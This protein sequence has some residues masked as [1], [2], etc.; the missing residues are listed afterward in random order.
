MRVKKVSI[1]I[2]L[3][4]EPGR[5]FERL[6][7]RNPRQCGE[8]DHYCLRVAGKWEFFPEGDPARTELNEALHRKSEREHE[9]RIGVAALIPQRTAPQPGKTPVADAVQKY[10]DNLAAMGKNE[11]SICT[12]RYA[13]SGF[14][15]S[16]KKPSIEDYEKQDLIDYMGWLRKQPRK[17]RKHANPERTYFNKV[18]HVA[19]FLKASGVRPGLKASEYPQYHEKQVVAHPDDELAVLY[20][21]ADEDERFLLDFFI[22]SMARD[23]E[24]YGKYGDP[25]LTGTTL[26]LYGKHHKTRTVEITQRLA[27]GIQKRRKRNKSKRLFMNPSGKPDKHLL[28]KLQDLAKRAGAEFHTELHKLR[29]TGASR[30]YRAG[31]L[32]PTLMEELGHDDLS[33]TQRYLSDVKPEATKQA[34]AAADFIPSCTLSESAA[35]EVNKKQQEEKSD[36]SR[37][38]SPKSAKVILNDTVR[39]RK[40][41]PRSRT[42][43]NRICGTS[44]SATL[45]S[46]SSDARR[47]IR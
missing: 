38:A 21:E 35:A 11:K 40:H 32:L 44:M 29:K 28:R 46:S 1:Y 3:S 24:A 23:H 5:P 25:D 26:T 2:R 19:I 41:L 6:K 31:E 13:V 42:W 47:A 33:T 27:D 30:R 18:S 7:V 43:T 8:R 17:E 34:V 45:L 9:L 16:Y 22:G 4:G 20:R 37:P 15:R 39:L 36:T 14:V 10:F 12:Y